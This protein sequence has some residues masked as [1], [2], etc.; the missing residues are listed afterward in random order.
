MRRK[1]R[2][3]AGSHAHCIACMGEGPVPFAGHCGACKACRA[4]AHTVSVETAARGARGLPYMQTVRHSAGVPCA[5]HVMAPTRWTKRRQVTAGGGEVPFTD[6]GAIVHVLASARGRVVETF[7]NS[8]LD[9]VLGVN[10]SF[11]ASPGVVPRRKRR[12]S[13]RSL[14]RPLPWRTLPGARAA[15]PSTCW[16]ARRNMAHCQ[17]R[18]AL[19]RDSCLR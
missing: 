7:K 2:P 1:R 4:A 6:Y 17:V 18:Y 3:A 16:R 8:Y 14:A 10:S 9:A 13:L 12:Q 5:A 19:R 15:A 11:R